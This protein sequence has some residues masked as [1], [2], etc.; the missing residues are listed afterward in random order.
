MFVWNTLDERESGLGLGALF[1][2]LP[3][4]HQSTLRTTKA[5]ERGRCRY[6]AGRAKRRRTR[7]VRRLVQLLFDFNANAEF[8]GM[9]SGVRSFA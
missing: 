9:D 3:S 2:Y 8:R 7:A 5:L 1:S 6:R 4:Q